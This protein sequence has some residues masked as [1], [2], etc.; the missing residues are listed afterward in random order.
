MTTPAPTL[1]DED[2]GRLRECL[3]PNWNGVFLVTDFEAVAAY[4]FD[5]GASRALLDAADARTVPR[6]PTEEMIE[7]GRVGWSDTNRSWAT[8]WRAM[9]DAAPRPRLSTASDAALDDSGTAAALRAQ[10]QELIELRSIIVAHNCA[11][12]QLR[13]DKDSWQRRAVAAEHAL[14]LYKE[15]QSSTELA[16]LISKGWTDEGGRT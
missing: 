15:P 14:K 9:Y 6:E 16:K 5:L 2:R 8:L 12:W 7:A 1:T 10:A 3:G 4:Y 11:G 13:R